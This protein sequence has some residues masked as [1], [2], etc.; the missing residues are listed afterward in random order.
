MGKFPELQGISDTGTWV[1][2]GFYALSTVMNTIKRSKIERIWAPVALIQALM[3]L[4]V[5]VG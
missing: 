3:V 5:A 4:M 1:V 2:L